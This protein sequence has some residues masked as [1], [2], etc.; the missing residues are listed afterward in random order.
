MF[1]VEFQKQK[2]KTACE[3][4]MWFKNISKILVENK[5]YTNCKEVMSEMLAKYRSL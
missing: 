4:W 1:D 5:K 3:G 2:N